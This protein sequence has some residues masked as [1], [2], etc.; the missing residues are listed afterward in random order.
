MIGFNLVDE[1]CPIS[2]QS[3]L[4]P[5]WTSR[6]QLFSPRCLSFGEVVSMLA[7]VL[8]SHETHCFS[9]FSSLGECPSPQRKNNSLRE[10]SLLSV[11]PS[12]NAK[13]MSGW[14]YWRAVISGVTPVLSRAG[15]CSENSDY[16]DMS[17]HRFPTPILTRL[18]NHL[19]VGKSSSILVFTKQ[20]AAT[21]FLAFLLPVPHPKH[22]P[23]MVF[24]C[25]A[26]E[27]NK[28][29]TAKRWP[30]SQA[31]CLR[32]WT[33]TVSERG[34]HQGSWKNI[35]SNVNLMLT[36]IFPL[37]PVISF[38]V[39][40]NKHQQKCKRNKK[41]KTLQNTSRTQLRPKSPCKPRGNAV[42]PLASSQPGAFGV[43]PG[44]APTMLP[45]PRCKR[46]RARKVL[47]GFLSCEEWFW[48]FQGWC[49]KWMLKDA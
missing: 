22:S 3:N 49:K 41:K 6:S 35:A 33:K 45:P 19:Q 12:N 15:I 11:L 44:K 46:C 8:L 16:R 24:N 25:R 7:G 14:E 4:N 34:K 17:F 37:A 42:A 28:A 5:L 23:S 13:A 26:P 21:M 38:T 32:P 10:T 27:S 47:G 39:W 9:S 36:N 1:Y 20:R 31:L 43:L 40:P 30:F 48:C 2:K 29:F 18:S